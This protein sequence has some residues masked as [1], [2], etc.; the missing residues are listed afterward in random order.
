MQRLRNEAGPEL[1]PLM[2]AALPPKLA[3]WEPIEAEYV[4]G[5]LSQG[6]D[7][8]SYGDGSGYEQMDRNTSLATWSVVRTEGSAATG[9]DVVECLR[10]NVSGWFPTVPRAETKAY[11]E[12]LR[13]AGNHATYVGDCKAV[14]DAATNGVP[15]KWVTWR[16]VNADLWRLV[17]HLQDDH[18]ALTRAVKVKSHRGRNAIDGKDDE[19]WWNG[20]ALPDHLAKELGKSMLSSR[21][22]AEE[23]SANKLHQDILKH[24]AYTA[25]W[26]LRKRPPEARAKIPKPRRPDL[27]TTNRGHDIVARHSGGWECAQCR[28][29]ALSRTGMRILK[30]TECEGTPGG[31]GAV[32][33]SH[34]METTRGVYWCTSC[35]AYTIRWPRVL[36]K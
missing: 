28:R 31:K 26:S 29:L 27:T 35:G 30:S 15:E 11:A 13:H 23:D 25:A 16:N 22:S 9:W 8:E 20:N 32:H 2:D 18:G 24:I 6:H 33:P 3:G 1:A 34:K 10:G 36:K 17:K 5:A 14:I 19:R 21:R 4:E 12:H 7:G